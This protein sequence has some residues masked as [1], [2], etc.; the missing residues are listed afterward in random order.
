MANENII[1][2][3]VIHILEKQSGDSKKRPGEKWYR[4]EYV[5]ET[6]EEY[7][8]QI[9]FQLWGEDR[10]QQANLQLGDFITVS[11]NIS[12]REYGGKWYTSID[13]RFVTKGDPNMMGGVQQ[14]SYPQANNPYAAPYTQPPTMG[15]FPNPSNIPG[16]YAQPGTSSIP[17]DLPF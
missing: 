6:M 2:G 3:K 15:G 10:I 7:P 4:Q 14:P 8:R 12:S 11:I 5:L 17:D 9:C 1:S 16:E 13:G